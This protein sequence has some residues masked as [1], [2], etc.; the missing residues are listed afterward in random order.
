MALEQTV[1]THVYR[2]LS[3]RA[4]REV[5]RG[6]RLAETFLRRGRPFLLILVGA[7]LLSIVAVAGIVSAAAVAIVLAIEAPMVLLSIVVFLGLVLLGVASI[8]WLALGRAYPRR[9]EDDSDATAE[10]ERRYV[11]GEIDEEE[12]EHRL[13][14]LF[15]A[16]E[17]A[18]PDGPGPDSLRLGTRERALDR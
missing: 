4:R 9:I 16:T 14:V 10:L 13:S 12:F 7:V 2:P 8:G 1:M 3:R 5:R 11:R 18:T 6:V 17:R 15:E